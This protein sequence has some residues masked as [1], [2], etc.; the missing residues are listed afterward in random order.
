[1][2]LSGCL[3]YSP[4]GSRPASYWVETREGWNEDNL[5]IL[6]KRGA[7]SERAIS[8]WF[9]YNLHILGVHGI[10]GDA[11][12]TLGRIFADGS[13]PIISVISPRGTPRVGSEITSL[14]IDHYSV[15]LQ[16]MQASLGEYWARYQ[17]N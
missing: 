13:N 2:V 12:E 17:S 15:M 1:M 9:P 4:A 10:L 6:G 3:G 7:F 11:S 8:T 14:R 16:R 5:L